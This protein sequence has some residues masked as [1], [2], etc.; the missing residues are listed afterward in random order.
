[1]EGTKHGEALS[2]IITINIKG[3]TANEL[4]IYEKYI[5]IFPNVKIQYSNMDVESAYTINFYRIDVDT[6]GEDGTL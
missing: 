1:M 5:K 4:E 6:L 3:A 2:G